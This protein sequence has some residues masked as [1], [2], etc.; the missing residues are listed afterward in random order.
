MEG[1]NH[2]FLIILVYKINSPPVHIRDNLDSKPSGYRV[3][4]RGAVIGEGEAFPGMLLAINPGG[5]NVK[6]PGTATVDPAFGDRKSV[7]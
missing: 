5:A 3:S 1:L 7:G 6:L 2:L 4:L